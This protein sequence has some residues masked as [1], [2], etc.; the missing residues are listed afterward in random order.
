[1]N[2]R[3]S[4]SFKSGLPAI[5][6][7]T[8]SQH[9]HTRFSAEP[10]RES[11]NGQAKKLS[12]EIEHS[13]LD[14]GHRMDG[15]A[16]VKCL[17]AAPWESRSWTA[18]FHGIQNRVV[19][20]DGTSPHQRP[21]LFENLANSFPARH[22]PTPVLSASSVRMTTFSCEVRACRAAQVQQHAVVPRH[23]NDPIA[24][25]RG[26]LT[27]A[28]YLRSCPVFS[29]AAIVASPMRT[30]P[31]LKLSW[32]SGY[33]PGLDPVR[34]LHCQRGQ[35][36][37]ASAAGRSKSPAQGS[38]SIKLQASYFS[39]EWTLWL[40]LKKDKTRVRYLI[41]AVLFAVSCFSYGDGLALPSRRRDV[42]RHR[43]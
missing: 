27:F 35:A 30:P 40:C 21:R 43:A 16:Q 13:G 5:A 10:S 8:D 42:K 11:S 6:D 41:I 22:P 19:R 32:C 23:R 15:D 39:S 38:V 34:S 18:Q 20:R 4:G 3:R 36:C 33:I 9:G 29:L 28:S 17:L 7:K 37:L 2:R 31:K 1:M 12:E 14:P 25:T 24:V 26:E